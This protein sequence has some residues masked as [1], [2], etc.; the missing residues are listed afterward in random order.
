VRRVALKRI[1]VKTTSLQGVV[2]AARVRLVKA[3]S[4]RISNAATVGTHG[5]GVA[6]GSS[7]SHTGTDTGGA[8]NT[9]VL[10]VV[11]SGASSGCGCASSNASACSRAKSSG[12][13]RLGLAQTA[14]LL[15]AGAHG[16]AGVGSTA[17]LVAD[18]VAVLARGCSSA[19]ASHSTSGE[20]LGGVA[21]TVALAIVVTVAVDVHALIT[22]KL[23]QLEFFPVRLWAALKLS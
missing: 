1:V 16:A 6:H 8:G 12:L 7:R 13:G 21:N 9:L 20:T 14:R 5:T 17:V 4:V 22:F 10:M 19:G 11:M 15:I 18:T 2:L 23:L 3:S